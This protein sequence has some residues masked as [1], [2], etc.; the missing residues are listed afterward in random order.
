MSKQT[1]SWPALSKF[2]AMGLPMMPRPMNPI[3]MFLIFLSLAARSLHKISG[4]RGDVIRRQ[5]I[6]CLQI[7]GLMRG[8][9]E[10]VVQ[11]YVV[12][13]HGTTA[14]REG[15]GRSQSADVTVFFGGDDSFHAL[16]QF[17]SALIVKWF[18]G[19]DAR[20]LGADAFFFQ[21]RSRGE[22]FFP[23][24]AVGQKKHVAPLPQNA[25][26]SNFKRRV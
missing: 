20:D 11:R 4:F 12:H 9:A 2:L 17:H 25:E 1:T 5:A 13:W 24:H 6:S 14:Q 10:R 22:C 3:F 8:F 21:N 18:H 7:F 16:G 19:S 26:F 15:R 23:H